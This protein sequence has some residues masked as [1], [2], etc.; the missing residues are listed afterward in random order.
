MV[1][2]TTNLVFHSPDATERFAHLL[3]NN[4]EKG[5]TLLLS[6]PVGAGKS[7]FARTAIRSLLA[8]EED[9]PS[10]TFTLVQTYE[11]RNGEIWHADL[12][13]LS[14]SLE[15]LELGLTDAFSQAICIVEWPDRLG[16]LV[17]AD[18]L[19]LSFSMTE[20]DYEREVEISWQDGTWDKR[21]ETVLNDHAAL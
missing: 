18:A 11:G 21:L 20:K 2:R 7:H 14:D 3:A 9:I 6:G 12:Y 1:A 10:P 15:V 16:Q 13:R 19:R 4:L 8:H 17:P 5:D